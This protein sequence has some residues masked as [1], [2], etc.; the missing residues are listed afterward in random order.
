MYSRKS[1]IKKTRRKETIAKSRVLLWKLLVVFLFLIIITGVLAWQSGNPKIVIS[2]I[3]VVGNDVTERSVIESIAKSE[4]NGKYLFVFSK[5][6]IALYPKN[7]IIAKILATQKR[8][9]DVGIY[10]DSLTKITIKVY[11]RLP[12]YIVCANES[13]D[14][15]MLVNEKCFFSDEYGYIFAEAPYFSD[16]V[17]FEWRLLDKNSIQIDDRVLKKGDFLRLMEFKNE[18]RR[19]GFEPVSFFINTEK[20]K[21]ASLVLRDGAR[22]MLSIENDMAVLVDN[23]ES[24]MSTINASGEKLDYVDLRFGS[25]VFYKFIRN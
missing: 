4:I 5:D 1:I 23:L 21:E 12:K 19:V 11:E 9:Y 8:I 7:D 15:D 18:V 10:R 14:E 6:N 3:N 13:S 25:K 24:V 17:F 16:K 20:N 22:I 2:E